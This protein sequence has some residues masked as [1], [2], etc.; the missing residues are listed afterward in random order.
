MANQTERDDTFK[1]LNAARTRA[2]HIPDYRIE[3]DRYVIF[4][5]IHKGDREKGSDDFVRNEMI[6]CYAL[7]YY[8]DQG[9]RLILN[10]DVEEG[11]EADY[12]SIIQA[13]EST[14]FAME[15][16]F[17]RQGGASYLRIYGNHDLEWADS[18][19]VKEHLVP[20]L[21]PIQV[22]PAVRLGDRIFIV[23]G[24]QGEPY[25]DKSAG[26]SRLAVRYFWRPL[27]HIFGLMSNRAAEDN[28]IRRNRDRYLYEWAE[29]NH[30][31]LIAGHTHRAMFRSFSKTYQ[32]KLIRDE[33]I[34]RLKSTTDPYLRF[35]LPAAIERINQVIWASS[36]E[37]ER[38]KE[39][40]RLG[41]DPTP[42]YFNDGCCVHTNGMTGIE[43]DQ[44]EIRLVKWEISDTYCVVGGG[45]RRRPDLFANIER[46]IYQ[47]DDLGEILSQV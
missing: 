43:L 8:L 44:G 21:G 34:E 27:Q 12:P 24:H 16:H 46:R 31:L 37:L 23:H 22:Y 4:S 3:S 5:D 17:A 11:W 20:V 15:R 14:A 35:L 6:Y 13:Y 32:L 36:E 29:A 7:Q 19:Q 45:V 2:F 30:L 40:S 33:L 9:Y 18:A 28:L 42:C 1:S 25:S 41:H 26:L 10:G 47:T 38:D 39:Q